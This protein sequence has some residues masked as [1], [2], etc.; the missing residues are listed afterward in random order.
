M[1][2]CS[3]RFLIVWLGRSSYKL[4]SNKNIKRKFKWEHKVI[5]RVLWYVFNWVDIVI[6]EI[7]WLKNWATSIM[8]G[9]ST[10]TLKIKTGGR[11]TTLQKQKCDRNPKVCFVKINSLLFYH[12]FDSSFK[13]MFGL[14]LKYNTWDSRQILYK[15][16][17]I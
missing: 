15:T 17:G 6:W 13:K 1:I 5:L 7:N 11:E 14:Y 10:N 2:H 4:F 16:L 8:L 3:T 12:C 9:S